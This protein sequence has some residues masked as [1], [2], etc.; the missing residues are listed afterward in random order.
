M[1]LLDNHSK[2]QAFLIIKQIFT[3]IIKIHGKIE[4]QDISMEMMMMLQ[5]SGGEE[6]ILE[7]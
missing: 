7:T 3:C 5:P 4:A 2:L 6:G 1:S